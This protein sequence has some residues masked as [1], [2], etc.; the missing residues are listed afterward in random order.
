[1][2]RWIELISI[3]MVLVIISCYRTNLFEIE[4]NK[5]YLYIY[6]YQQK[7]K[8]DQIFWILACTFLVLFA[9]LRIRYNDTTT[10]LG[11]FS[12]VHLTPNLIDYLQNESFG[13]NNYWGYKLFKSCCRTVGMDSHLILLTFTVFYTTIYLWF[14]RKYADKYLVLCMF[15]FIAD[16]YLM[17]LAALKQSCATAFA[18]LAVDSILDGKRVR[19]VLW[20]IIAITFHP[21]VFVLFLVPLL[22]DK[23]PWSLTTWAAVGFMTVSGLFMGRTAIILEKYNDT[24]NAASILDHTMNPLRFLVAL[25]PVLISF[26]FRRILY[27]DATV[28]EKLFAN[29]SIIRT[30]FYFWALFGNPIMFARVANYFD[31]FNAIFWGWSLQKLSNI[32]KTSNVGKLLIKGFYAGFLIFSFKN[33]VLGFQFTR[34]TEHMSIYMLI[35]SIRTWLGG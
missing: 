11:I 1:M 25:V 7:K 8:Q 35:Q 22:M 10:Y 31:V 30:L 5:S 34:Q 18:L 3:P 21:Y 12:N 4:G 23:R 29:F 17:L 33:C 14:I 13:F 16:G 24:Y 6:N 28:P 19:Y 15:V 9:G 20:M 26:I 27:D 2:L 32:D